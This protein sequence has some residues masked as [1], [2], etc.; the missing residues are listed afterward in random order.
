MKYHQENDGL[1]IVTAHSDDVIKASERAL[2]ISKYK[3]WLSKL[4]KGAYLMTASYGMTPAMYAELQEKD[5]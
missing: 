5:K 4:G 1:H 2:R 3:Y